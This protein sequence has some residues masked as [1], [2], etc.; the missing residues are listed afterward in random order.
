MTG[1]LQMSRRRLG[2]RAV[3]W[4]IFGMG[5]AAPITR[6]QLGG[7]VRHE[8]GHNVLYHNNGNGTFTDVT[9][10]A[11][12]AEPDWSTC[13][14]SFDYDGDRKTGPVRF[15]FCALRRRARS[16]AAK[17]QRTP[18]LLCSTGVQTTAEP[19]VP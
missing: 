6:Q 19:P 10:K 15:Q 7:F 4:A 17:S 14:V 1:R 11:G 8:L 18:L 2:S 12:V 13:A 3:R 9:D 16:Y 5:V